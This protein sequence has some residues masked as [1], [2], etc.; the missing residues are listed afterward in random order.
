MAGEQ[1]APR[2]AN[3]LSQP[4]LIKQ[5]EQAR[6]ELGRTVDAITEK[7]KPANVA[8]RTMDQL[9]QRA[10]T[11]DP[12]LAG[13]GAAVVVGVVALLVWRRRRR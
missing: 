9:K 12:K 3:D 2:A 4:A 13:A 6:L 10:Q 8:R 5:I 1:I 11:V 7:V